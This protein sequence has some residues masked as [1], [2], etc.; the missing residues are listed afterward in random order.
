[1]GALCV[2]PRPGSIGAVGIAVVSAVIAALDGH[3]RP[4]SF[5]SLYLF[6]ILP[7]AILSGFWIAGIIA[8]AS[9]LTF[10]FFFAAPLVEAELDHVASGLRGAMDELRE[11]ARG[12]HPAILAEG[13]L[14]PA[15]K[16]LG[17][18]SPVPVELNVRTGG[19]LPEAVEV[20]AYYVV[21]EALA[22]VAQHAQASSVGV[23]VE[24]GEGVLHV[25]VRDD[26]VGGADFR[27]GSG[28]VGLK[29]RVEALGGRITL[30]SESGRGTTLAA[31]LPLVG[32]G[33]RADSG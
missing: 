3:V 27:G 15:L 31:E 26:G 22:N 13:G 29:D 10:T 2:G 33:A 18:H 19:R 24:L 17:R 30:E 20:G 16:T 8:I 23:Q 12:I 6:A 7:V 11:Y 5:A 4:D 1:M 14:G 28:L 21:S 25:R 9:F 32:D